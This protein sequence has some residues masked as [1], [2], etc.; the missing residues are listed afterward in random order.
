MALSEGLLLALVSMFSWGVADFIVVGPIRSIGKI[1][2]LAIGQV[3]IFLVMLV[4]Y[5]VF[6]GSIHFTS[7][8]VLFSFLPSLLIILGFLALYKGLHIGKVSLITPIVSSWSLVS[9]VVG[10][11]IFYQVPTFHQIAGALLIISGMFMAVVNVSEIRSSIKKHVVK[12]APEALASMIFFGSSL[13]FGKM[14]VDNVGWL[15]ASFLFSL[16]QTLMI[17]ALYFLK[18]EEMT[19]PSGR[20]VLIAAM[21]GILNFLG[22]ISYNMG[23]STEYLSVVSPIASASVLVTVVLSFVVLKERLTKLQYTGVASVI[24]GIIIMAI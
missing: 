7:W 19:K 21:A 18:K 9:I 3:A 20:H 16:W 2:T 22:A 15:S 13:A 11:L 17:A 5:A 1:K 10:F 14:V 4:S 6:P 12:G 23:I 24:S 8:A